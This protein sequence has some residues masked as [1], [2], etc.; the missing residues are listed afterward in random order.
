MQQWDR[1][2]SLC[3]LQHGRWEVHQLC[4]G[5]WSEDDRRNMHSMQWDVEHRKHRV[6]EMQ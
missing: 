6:Q 4:G 2:T 5:V 1:R 3:E